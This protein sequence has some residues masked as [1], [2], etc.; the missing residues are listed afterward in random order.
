ML[1]SL[2]LEFL[3]RFLLSF[4]SLRS[5]CSRFHSV[6][7]GCLLKRAWSFPKRTLLY[8]VRCCKSTL[9]PKS[10]LFLH[11]SHINCGFITTCIRLWRF[12]RTFYLGSGWPQKWLRIPVYVSTY[13]LQHY[14]I[15]HIFNSNT[16]LKWK[17]IK[18]TSYQITAKQTLDK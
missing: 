13:I 16:Q 2:L 12:L 5:F 7:H 4:Y 11:N 9:F 3:L 10:T 17:V 18:C 8:F 6:V 1:W 15:W 14:K